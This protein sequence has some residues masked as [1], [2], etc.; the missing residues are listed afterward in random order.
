[1]NDESDEELQDW[2]TS[3]VVSVQTWLGG[4]V[5]PM[6]KTGLAHSTWS[7]SLKWLGGEGN[8]LS[9]DGTSLQRLVCRFENGLE[10]KLI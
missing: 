6:K 4:A 3:L 5:S 8:L 10:G 9:N 7:V 2:L 1:M